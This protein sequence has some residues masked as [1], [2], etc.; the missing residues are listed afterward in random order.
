MPVHKLGNNQNLIWN[1]NNYLTIIQLW[2]SQAAISVEMTEIYYIQW[3]MDTVTNW[4]TRMNNPNTLCATGNYRK[5]IFQFVDQNYSSE[6]IYCLP[7][8]TVMLLYWPD[9]LIMSNKLLLYNV[10]GLLTKLGWRMY[11]T[12]NNANIHSI[13]SLSLNSTK[14]RLKVFIGLF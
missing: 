8:W 2:S 12:C 1:C 7:K 9:P 6:I 3:I 4:G 11:V 10:L 13:E 14:L 5:N